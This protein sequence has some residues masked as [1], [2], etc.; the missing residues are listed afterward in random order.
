MADDN[1]R[2][3]IL[4]AAS[5]VFCEKGFD[6]TTVRDICTEADANVAAVNYHFGDKQKLYNQVL[7]MWVKE[8]V[9]NEDHSRGVGP[10]SRAEDRLRAFIRADLKMLRTFDHPSRHRLNRIRLLLRE[11]TNDEKD[12]EI[13]K[14]HK[15]LEEKELSP[16]VNDLVGPTSSE[17]FKQACIAATGMITHYSV[18]AIHDPVEGVDSEEKLEFMTDF[19][20]TFVLGG[21]KAIREKND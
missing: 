11:V 12:P 5:R 1:T 14:C 21:L 3:R 10:D 8:F 4:S 15:N 20:T 6:G 7:T 13:F 19:L 18:M 9:E 16:I 17:T 2:T